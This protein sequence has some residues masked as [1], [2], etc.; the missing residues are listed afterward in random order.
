MKK[1]VKLTLAPWNVRTLLDSTTSM[2]GRPERR[3]ALEARELAHYRVNI[4]A[5]SETYFPDKGQLTEIGGGYTF[6]WSG[7]RSVE[8]RETGVGFAIKDHLVKK[9]DSTPEGLN[10]RL[11][12]LKFPIGR[13]RSATL[14]GACAPTLTSPD[15][16]K[17]KFYEELEALISAVPQSDKLILLGDFNARVG[18]DH[19]VWE[20]IIGHHGVGKCSNSNGLLLLRTCSTHG[21]AITN[22]M[23][24]LPTRNKTSWMHPRSKH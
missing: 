20:G 17:E 3:T 22:T 19:Q 12:K 4:A 13:K 5:L 24:R 15:E 6:F 9:L 2:S 18:Q 16:V 21:L 14:I 8:R 11:M 1:A 7:R 23:F 10:D